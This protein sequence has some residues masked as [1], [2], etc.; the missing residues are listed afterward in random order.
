MDRIFEIP[1][2][3]TTYDKATNLYSKTKDSNAFVESTLNFVENFTKTALETA[4]P[5]H[6]A[7]EAPLVYA[8]K[9]ACQQLTKLEEKYPNVKLTPEEIV[10]LSKN[11]YEKSSLK[12]NVD[13]TVAV[14]DYAL[15]K[16]KDG[17]QTVSTLVDN[18]L[19]FSESLV[20]ATGLETPS[21][22]TIKTE[23]DTSYFGRLRHVT[24]SI[25]DGLTYRFSQYQKIFQQTEQGLKS[26][27]E[28]ASKNVGQI[29]RVD[30]DYVKKLG[31][32]TVSRFHQITTNSGVNSEKLLLNVF[33]GFAHSIFRVSD[34]LINFSKPY[35]N[36]TTEKM[37]DNFASYIRNVNHD[38]AETQ[39]VR[40]VKEKSVNEAKF[41]FEYIWLNFTH[42]VSLSTSSAKKN[43]DLK[44]EQ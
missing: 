20:K 8:N 42:L 41:V 30:L 32:D 39:S 7:L 15:E 44:K 9:M 14:K 27:A 18:S 6:Q 25:T 17:R 16:V 36:E 19:T 24:V 22:S 35:F 1:L 3:S 11:Y 31:H 23:F 28:S 29:I 37:M 40:E 26:N 21:T 33:H 34:I 38:F 12:N 10:A 43:W 13:K 2:I 4:Q 5:I